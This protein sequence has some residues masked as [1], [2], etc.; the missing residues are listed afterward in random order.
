VWLNDLS[1]H[2]DVNWQEIKLAKDKWDCSQ[3]GLTQA[4]ALIIVLIVTYLTLGTELAGTVT[5]WH[6]L[7]K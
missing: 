1:Q 3:E 7:D 6:L 2:K 5:K 4:G